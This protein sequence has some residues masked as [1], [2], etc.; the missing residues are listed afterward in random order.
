MSV[1][2]GLATE[3]EGRRASQGRLLEGG[4]YLGTPKITRLCLAY[5]GEHAATRLPLSCSPSPRWPIIHLKPSPF[6]V[7]HSWGALHSPIASLP[8]CPA[9]R[10]EPLAIEH[11]GD[12]GKSS[13]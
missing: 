9:I 10:Q 5:I 13:G 2:L 11:A 1:S 3:T 6:L 7:S 12:D 8:V 4:R